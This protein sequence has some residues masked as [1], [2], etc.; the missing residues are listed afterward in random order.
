M[1]LGKELVTIEVTSVKGFRADSDGINCVGART[2]ESA[3]KC[4]DVGIECIIRIRPGRDIWS[5]GDRRVVTSEAAKC[6]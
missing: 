4:T 6:P 3:L 1:D 2:L 5:V